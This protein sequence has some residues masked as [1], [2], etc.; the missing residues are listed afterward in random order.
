LFRLNPPHLRGNRIPF[1]TNIF[2]F[3]ESFGKRALL[4]YGLP[5]KASEC[6]LIISGAASFLLRYTL[7]SIT[8]L[9]AGALFKGVKVA[10][11]EFMCKFRNERW[12]ILSN[13][14]PVK[15]GKEMMAFYLRNGKPVFSGTEHPQD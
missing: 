12:S 2:D 13:C 14:F 3:F 10:D 8:F 4:R 11:V 15:P 6:I 1:D 5:V 7:F 9:P